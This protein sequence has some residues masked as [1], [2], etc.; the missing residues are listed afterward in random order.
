MRKTWKP[1]PAADLPDGLLLFDGYCHVCSGGV[2]FLL[3]RD[4][5]QRFTYVPCQSPWGEEIMARYGIDRD[6]A[7]SFAFVDKG[8][9]L[10]KSD[11]AIASAI[12]LPGWRWVGVFRFLPQSLRD[13]AYDVLAR[14]RYKWFGKRDTCLVL[15]A[16]VRARFRTE[17]P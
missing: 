1:Q 15:P 3:A 2:R 10:F 12:R 9:I 14:N 11:A 8:R 6:F 4:E 13:W 16:G 17:A 5:A 7:E